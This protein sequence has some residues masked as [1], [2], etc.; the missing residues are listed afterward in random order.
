MQARVLDLDASLLEQPGLRS[1]IERGRVR[2]LSLR[3]I[4][5]HLRIVAN[6]AALQELER[7]LALD[8]DTRAPEACVNFVGSGDFHHVTAVLLARFAEPLTVIH[9]DNHPDWVTWPRNFNCGGWVNRALDLPNV[10][11]VITL[12]PCS[13]DLQRPETKF[14]NLKA[15]ESGRLEVYPWRHGPSRVLRSYGNGASHATQDGRIVWT[16]LAERPW[17]EFIDTLLTRVPTEA[18]YL[19]LDKD[20]LVE[21]DAVTNWDQGEMSVEH[22]LALI[23][24]I[25]ATHR[26]VGADVCGEYSVPA[27]PGW[28]RKFLS[29]A[30]RGHSPPKAP[31]SYP[32]ND[33]TNRRLLDAFSRCAS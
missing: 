6:R 15:L 24:R 28:G 33:F 11:R 9:V 3:D 19:T 22:V 14:A 5:D 25:T 18:V 4:A 1:A 29:W 8:D 26:L 7:R 13:A 21:A 16:T 30:D 20:A 10:Q 2:C 32:Q 27:F 31:A 12:G 17:S 23:E